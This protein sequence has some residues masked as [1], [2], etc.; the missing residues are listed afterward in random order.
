MADIY[1]SS[2]PDVKGPAGSFLGKYYCRLLLG[3]YDRTRPFEPGSWKPTQSIFLPIPKDLTDDTYV[4]YSETALE[5]VGDLI[6]F[7]FAGLGSRA[8]LNAVGP[9]L[10]AGATATMAGLFGSAGEKIADKIS[11]VT[12]LSSKNITSA[13]Q[14][15]LGYSPNPNPA[16]LFTGP[17]LREFNFTWALYPKTPDESLH[18]D[19]VIKIL[20]KAALPKTI[21]S[22]S[23]GVLKY[24][25]L[26]QINFFPWDSGGGGDQWGWTNDSIIRIKKCFLK[27]VKVNYSDFGNPAFFHGTE[28]PVMYRLSITLQEVEY[29]LSNDWDVLSQTKVNLLEST[30][31]QTAEALKG[32]K[33][34][35]GEILQG[36]PNVGDQTARD[37][38]TFAASTGADSGETTK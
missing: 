9:I 14:S 27:S 35:G 33:S 11:D 4:S 3:E 16:V 2:A 12:G 24:P 22:A 10:G 8:A 19:K 23:T 17:Q 18:V 6:N 32:L 37:L 31:A 30:D 28:L 21:W 13:A 25:D 15:A 7:D 20:K 34:T 29:M 36:L 5:G 38:L 26:C 1:A